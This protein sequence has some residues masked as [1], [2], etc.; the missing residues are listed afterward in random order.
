MEPGKKRLSKYERDNLLIKLEK[1]FAFTGAVI[2]QEIALGDDRVRLRHLVFEMSKKRGMLSAEDIEEINAAISLIR[3]KR[4]EIVGRIATEEIDKS[5]ADELFQTALGLD[6]ALDTLYNVTEPKTS[7]AEEAKKAKIEEGRR[8]L[9]LIR[10][11]Y[12]HEEKRK[13]D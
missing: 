10:R 11:V 4:R 9:G 1:E 8:W 7:V 5:E 3:K 2:P 13:R 6:R 12:S